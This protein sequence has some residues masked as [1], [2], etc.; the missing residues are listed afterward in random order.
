LEHALR[1][2]GEKS[3]V[4]VFLVLKLYVLADIDHLPLV[5]AVSHCGDERCQLTAHD[6]FFMADM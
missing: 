3:F 6:G 4:L 1:F 2:L 5:G